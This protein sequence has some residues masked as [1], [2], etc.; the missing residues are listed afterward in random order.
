MPV[1]RHRRAALLCCGEPGESE[2]QRLLGLRELSPSTAPFLPPA[3]AKGRWGRGE[4][5]I[6][7]YPSRFETGCWAQLVAV[8]GWQTPEFP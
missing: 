5:L 3:L 6:A 8:H 4:G 2:E 7:A 1:G